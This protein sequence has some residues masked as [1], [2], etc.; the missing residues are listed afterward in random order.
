VEGVPQRLLDGG[1]LQGT[2]R[3]FTMVGIKAIQAC[4]LIPF[5]RTKM[6]IGLGEYKTFENFNN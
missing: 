3:V 5:L 4:N 6:F 1:K 2:D